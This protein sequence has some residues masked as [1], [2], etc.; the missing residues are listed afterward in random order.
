MSPQTIEPLPSPPGS[1]LT[2][3]RRTL[4]LPCRHPPDDAPP[5]DLMVADIFGELMHFKISTGPP[6]ASWRQGMAAEI[7]SP[8]QTNPDLK[9]RV[10]Q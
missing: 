7:T 9:G 10:H 2:V 6:H 5:Q 8:F 1:A 4:S 3:H